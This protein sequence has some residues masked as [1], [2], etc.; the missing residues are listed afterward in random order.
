MQLTQET[1]HQISF[2]STSSLQ[3]GLHVSAA[4]GAGAPHAFLVDTGSVG[5]LV[6]RSKL[7]PGY[8]NFDPTLDKTFRYVSSGKLYH[9]QRV[10]VPVVLGVP[11]SWDGTG[12]YPSAEIEVFAV[13]Q[14]RDFTGG[15][16]GIGFAIGGSADGGPARNPLLQMTYKGVSLGQA[17]I[18]SSTGIELGLTGSTL[19]NFAFVALKRDSNGNWEQPLGGIKL[20]SAHGGSRTFDS[21]ILMDT[22]IREMI[23]WIHDATPPF[24][25]PSDKPFPAGI[26]VTVSLPAADREAEPALD[27]TFLTGDKPQS[28][29]PSHVEWRSGSGLNTGRN[30]LAGYDYL[31]DA[32]AG[33]IGFRS[34]A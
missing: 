19:Q 28:M 23:L 20:V 11:S 12:D 32:L 9:G 3:D 24:E 13:D 15:V 5:I 21:T 8:Q 1:S 25:L 17:Y 31:Y 18:V 22:G 26:T 10:R 27:Y 34:H 16:F 14:P 4:L 6:P 2:T 7:G 30:V 33:R 29:A